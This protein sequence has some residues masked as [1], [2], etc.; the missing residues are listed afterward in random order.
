MTTQENGYEITAPTGEVTLL[1]HNQEEN[2][3]SVVHDGVST[4]LFRFN[5]DGTIQA[6]LQNGEKIDVTT[7][8]AGLYKVRMAVNG[9]H[10]FAVD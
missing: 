1:C 3:W 6:S 10:F 4:E 8:E 9:G 7:D 5:G 2:S